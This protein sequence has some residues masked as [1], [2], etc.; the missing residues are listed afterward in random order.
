MRQETEKIT[1]DTTINSSLEQVWLCWTLEEHIVE[2]NFVNNDCSCP[3]A[4][5][6]LRVGGTFDFR[7]ESNNGKSNFAVK[8]TYTEIIRTKFLS[9]QFEDGRRE[10]IL[11]EEIDG[12]IRLVQSF[13]PSKDA[14]LVI[15][16]E[17]DNK[18]F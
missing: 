5:N 16:K 3:K 18:A 15:F 14:P 1:I 10:S 4:Y 6:N 2:W 8:G 11:F 12:Q 7:M 9:Y 13:E 17:R